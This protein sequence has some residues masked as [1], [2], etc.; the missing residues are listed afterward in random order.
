MPHNDVLPSN[1]DSKTQAQAPGQKKVSIISSVFNEEAVIHEF[2]DRILQTI[3]PLNDRYSFEIILVDDKSL[4]K[5]LDL[6]KQKAMQDSRIRIIEFRRNYGQTHALQ[7]GIDC[8]RGDVIISLD[9]DLQHFPEEIPQFLNKIEE[10]Y[11]LVCGW[12]H[13]RRENF[14]RCWPSAA[15][16]AVIRGISRIPIHDFGTTYRAYRAELINEISLL[17]EFHRFVPVLV[18]NIGGQI[19]EIPIQNIPRR[20]GKSNYGLGRTT[21]VALDLILLFFLTHYLDRPFRIYGKIALLFFAAGSAILG[22]LVFWAYYH[23][24]HAAQEYIGWFI[25]SMLFLACSLQIVLIGIISEVMTRFHFSRKGERFY[26]IR[27]E[28]NYKHQGA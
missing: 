6:M 20:S 11:D 23:H 2:I 9:S 5:S 15:A 16:N 8:A 21:G 24:I 4:D 3:K 12:R 26:K 25:L 17:G 19:T 7:C 28:F 13:E 14:I 1:L 10:G 22:F 27:S 18:G